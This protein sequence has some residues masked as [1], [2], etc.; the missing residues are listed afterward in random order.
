M[1]RA[2]TFTPADRRKMRLPQVRT[3]PYVHVRNV[4]PADGQAIEKRPRR[5]CTHTRQRHA[6][7][8]GCE[9]CMALEV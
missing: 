9:K 3:K 4:R 8:D 1:G 6:G 2:S 5:S 7:A